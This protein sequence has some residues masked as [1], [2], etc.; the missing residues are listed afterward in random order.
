MKECEDLEQFGGHEFAAELTLDENNL[1]VWR[2]INQI[3]Y[4]G[5]SALL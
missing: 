3:A 1:Q 2:R 4:N 5:L